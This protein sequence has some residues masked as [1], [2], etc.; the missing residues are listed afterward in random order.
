MMSSIIIVKTLLS[1]ILY[2]ITRLRKTRDKK[3]ITSA[4]C[5]KVTKIEFMDH[6]RRVRDENLGC[7]SLSDIEYRKTAR[8]RHPCRLLSKNH[9]DS[10]TYSCITLL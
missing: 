2:D 6:M 5:L 7:L 8:D 3:G 1:S 4:V 10:Y 9:P